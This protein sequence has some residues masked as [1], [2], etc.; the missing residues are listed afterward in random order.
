MSSN[1]GFG[2]AVCLIIAY[3]CRCI[4]LYAVAGPRARARG[5]P[6]RGPRL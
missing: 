3:S 4:I 1:F 2:V 5:A 6:H